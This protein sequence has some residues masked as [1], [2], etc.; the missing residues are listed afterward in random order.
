M[1]FILFIKRY[2]ARNF[3]LNSTFWISKWQ[4]TNPK[5]II[6][7]IPT[8]NRQCH[9]IRMEIVAIT[10]IWFFNETFFKFK[11]G[12]TNVRIET[13]IPSFVSC[14]LNIPMDLIIGTYLTRVKGKCYFLLVLNFKVVPKLN[15]HENILKFC[16]TSSLW[17]MQRK[18]GESK[19]K[20][21][22]CKQ[23][24]KINYTIIILPNY[25]LLDF[26]HF[27]HKSLFPQLNEVREDILDK[28]PVSGH[29]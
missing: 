25:F 15:S 14:K 16:F 23:I 18:I 13:W 5:P 10:H 24:N 12:S 1:K 21:L 20:E 8:Q 11:N 6:I 2:Y 27:F 29:R 22:K 4:S 19:W 17:M 26:L 9:F 3:V 28:I 7:R